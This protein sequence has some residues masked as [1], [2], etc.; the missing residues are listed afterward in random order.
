LGRWVENDL[1]KKLFLNLTETEI[2]QEYLNNGFHSFEDDKQFA[3]NIFKTEI[4]NFE[5]LHDFF[6]NQ[7]IYWIDDIDWF[8]QWF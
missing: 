8:A 7:S 6:E 3:L 1:M 4:A 5:L 2:Y